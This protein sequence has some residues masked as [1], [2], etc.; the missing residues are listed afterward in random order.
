MMSINKF[1]V[2]GTLRPDVQAPWS[3]IVHNNPEFKLKYYKAYL[4]CS[5]LFFHRTIGFPMT[6]YDV[7]L[8]S[9][10]D[11]TIGYILETD[12]VQQTLKLFD[13]IECYPDEYDRFEVKCFNK[14]N[15]VFESVYFYSQKKELLK[16]EDLEDLRI[17]DFL[18]MKR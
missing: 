1:F 2:Y 5:K 7:E 12:N 8:Y 6:V 9:E 17:N 11:K 15:S 18:Y 10:E 4:P 14:E 16:D 13:E 3:D